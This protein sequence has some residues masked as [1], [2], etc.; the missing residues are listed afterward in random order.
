MNKKPGLVPQKLL[1]PSIHEKTMLRPRLIERLGESEASIITIVAPAGFGKTVLLSQLTGLFNQPAVWYQLDEYDN[2][3]AV[4]WRYLIAGCKKLHPAFGNEIVSFIDTSQAGLNWVRTVLS[5][6]IKELDKHQDGLTLVFDDF[7]V[8]TQ[9]EVKTFIEE[10]LRHLPP[11]VKVLMA[12]RTDVFQ[13]NRL[14]AEGRIRKIDVEDLYFTRED[15]A[16]YYAKNG[17]ELT[18]A[19]LDAIRNGTN[20]WPI[21][22]GLS[23]NS[24]SRGKTSIAK[25]NKEILFNYMASEVLEREEPDTRG[26]LTAISVLEEITPEYCDLLLERKD[27]R[28]LLASLR[29]RH[30]F[31]SPLAGDSDIYRYHHLVRAFLLERL[32]DERFG[33]LEKAG[34]AAL[35]KGE[36]ERAVEYFLAA[37]IRGKAQKTMIEA[38]RKLIGRGNW[39]TVERWLGSFSEAEAVKNPWL[40]LYKAQIDVNRGRIFSGENWVNHSLKAFA[41][42]AERAGLAESRLLKAKILRYQGQYQDSLSLLEL[43]IPDLQQDETKER[44]DPYLEQSYTLWL[45]G[46]FAE[47]EEVLNRALKLAEQRGDTVLMTYFYEGL[48]TVTFGQG[49]YD[50]SMYY[51]RRGIAISPDK[52]LRNYY[53]QDS[54]GPIYLDWGELD[55][56]YE[57]LRQ[58]IAAKENFGLTEALPSAYFQLGNVL[59]VRREFPQAEQYFRKALR[60]IEEYGGD[61]VVRTLANLLLSICLRAQGR[62]VEAQDL[63]DKAR[64]QTENQSGY[65]KGLYQVVECLY[66]VQ[67]GDLETAYLRLHEI[68]P[69]VEKVEARKPL[70]IT[71]SALA[72]VAVSRGDEKDISEFTVK[73]LRLASEMNYVHDFL[74]LFETYQ[75][76]LYLGLERGIEVAFI[77]RI[78]VRLGEKAVPLLVKLTGHPDASVRER[79]IIPLAQIGGKEAM[80]AIKRLGKD[81]DP[82]ISELARRLQ[83]K[84]GS[85]PAAGAG[86]A[87][88]A[89]GYI[90]LELLGPVRMFSGDTEITHTRWIRSKSRD[91]LIYLAHLGG[92]ANKEKIIDA[93]WPEIPYEQANSLFHAALHDLRRTL[94]EVSGYKNLVLYRGGRYFL[95][96]DN[97]SIDKIHFQE[98]LAAAGSSRDLT[99]QLVS[100]LEEAVSLYRGDYLEELDYTWLIPEQE[101]LKQ[102]Y[103]RARDRLSAYYLDKKDYLQARIHLEHLARENPLTEKY[104]HRLISACAGV[105]DLKSVDLLY[106]RLKTLLKEEL[107]LPPSQEMQNLYSRLIDRR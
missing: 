11:R 14:L 106:H 73:A 52:S 57:Y 107:G 94:E 28:K 100:S 48:G 66:M 67:A 79:A 91:L 5:M 104:Y 29:R 83:P 26:F 4:F 6:L 101:Y 64:R 17:I 44:F 78:L 93:F 99:E 59:L 85:S 54:I 46:R 21:A 62:S 25:L 98:L 13:L 16:G 76:L 39:Q 31:L 53:F 88:A 27:S 24:P 86:T 34:D 7:H 95:S 92:P 36:I 71:Y 19:E 32:G 37:G 102:L 47:A 50:R 23:L 10:F 90:C 89:K 81:S 72:L 84:S 75:P 49:Y 33:L 61:R 77:Q 56:A 82:R 69:E 103:N 20:G 18:G 60:I 105:G 1:A 51:Y 35:K 3:P 97:L 22:V 12:G 41:D 55:Q 43:A 9:P 70:C 8:L 38:G 63:F 74:L 80:G 45:S 96:P 2:D 68:L 15:I 87:A 65:L 40:S 30:F 58:S 42:T